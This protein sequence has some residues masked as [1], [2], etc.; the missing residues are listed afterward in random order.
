MSW[1]RIFVIIVFSGAGIA[2]LLVD[3]WSETGLL[4]ILTALFLSVIVKE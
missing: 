2:C 3:Q 1:K 4:G